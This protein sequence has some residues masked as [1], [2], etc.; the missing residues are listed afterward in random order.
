MVKQIQKALHILPDGIYGVNTQEAVKQFQ[1]LH[2]LKVD[3]IVGPA[4]LAMLIPSRLKRSKRHINEIIIHCTATPEGRD[5]T[6]SDIRRWHTTPK[7]QGGNG[8]S[9]IGYH[10]VI[11][12]NG[13]IEPGRDVD[14]IGA[15]C[16]GH[17]TY[18]IG[19][20]YVGDMSADGK[21]VKDTRTLQQ[22]AALL[23]L[24]IDLRKLYPKARICGHRDFSVK[25]CP[26]FDA[27]SEYRRI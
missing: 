12:R 3:G 19:V 4:T 2:G 22:K 16:D 7:S 21:T 13:H 27:T 1:A 5:Y 11:Y 18:S 26:S 9:D 10:Y 17:N 14:V 6:V 15:H 23:N 25:K 8:W 24:L 20:C